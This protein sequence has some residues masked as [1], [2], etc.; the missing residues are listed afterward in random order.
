MNGDQPLVSAIIPV[1]NGGH[2]VA[3]AITSILV[4]TYAPIECI[5]VD[6]GST[7]GSAGVVRR[8]GDRVTYLWRPRGGVAAARNAGARAARGQ[9]LAFLDADDTWV[10]TKIERQMALLA[11]RPGLGLVYGSV[12]RIDVGGLHGAVV[13]APRPQDALRNV[14]LQRGPG[15]ALAQT[16]LIPSSVFRAIGGFDERLSTAAD[17]D[18]ACRIALRCEL[19]AVTEPLASYR[20]H[21]TQMHLDI[22]PFEHDV[23][24][25]LRKAFGSGLLPAELQ[26]LRRRAHANLA[27][28]LAYLRYADG[29]EPRAALRQLCV[30]FGFAPIE[31]LKWV[32]GAVARRAPRR[33]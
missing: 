31:T 18:L 1:Y 29:A 25:L 2:Y 28:T 12:R 17:S 11:E 8:F 9:F 26:R 14:L 32:A 7:D 5:V 19:A 20:S 33:A 3:E 24:L 22:A 10:E 27:F 30:A 13:P 6:D 21:P 16:G 15:V 23:K 4:Q